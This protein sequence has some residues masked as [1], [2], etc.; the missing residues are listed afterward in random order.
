MTTALGL[1]TAALLVTA[2]PAAQAT[3]STPHVSPFACD[4]LALDP[5]A[6]HR[7]FDELGPMLRNM[8]KA[9]RELPDGYEFEFAGDA[10]TYALVNEWAQGERLCCPFFDI[11]IRAEREDGAVWLRLTGRDGT[12]D[13]IKSDFPEQWTRK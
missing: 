10:K 4:R 8:R 2:Q 1:L 11:A 5:A 3:A 12:K 13:F 7:H 9:T 6:R